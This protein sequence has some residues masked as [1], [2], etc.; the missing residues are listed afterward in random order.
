MIPKNL[1]F[2]S[3]L[4][5]RLSLH[6]LRNFKV[7]HNKILRCSP[8]SY[9]YSGTSVYV[10]NPFQILQLI[11]NRTYTKRIFPIRNKGKMIRLIRSH[12]KKKILL[13]LAYYIVH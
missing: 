4:S 12:E 8:V 10:L 11:Q 3:N 1:C 5:V 13:L 2:Y 7:F 9:I 6:V